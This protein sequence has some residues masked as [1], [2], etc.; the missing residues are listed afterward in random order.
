MRVLID[1]NIWLDIILG[2][3]EFYDPAFAVLCGCIDGDEE[4]CVAATTLKDVFYI[5]ER[6]QGAEAA[7][8]AVERMLELARVVAVDDLVCRRALDLE[9]PDY[10]DGIIAAAAEA[11]AVD[12]IV[13]RD[14]DAFA[15]AAARRLTPV[16]LMVECGWEVAA[17]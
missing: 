10:G 8:G 3:E 4:M 12:L 7:Y 15:E 14:E 16:Q 6:L 5:V 9:R 1:T 17:I 13:T 2:R 11:D